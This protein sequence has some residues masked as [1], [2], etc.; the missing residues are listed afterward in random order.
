MGYAEQTDDTDWRH[1]L[2]RILALFSLLRY[3]ISGST[4]EE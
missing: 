3:D 1:W 4:Q 2:I